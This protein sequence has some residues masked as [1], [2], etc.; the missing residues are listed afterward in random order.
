M[1]L[2]RFMEDKEA[3]PNTDLTTQMQLQ[4]EEAELRKALN[5][6]T[7][8]KFTGLSFPDGFKHGDGKGNF[9]HELDGAH[10]KPE[11]PQPPTV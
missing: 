10:N 6:A 4:R 8:E 7:H 3:N 2:S 5:L 1:A 11:Y 9:K